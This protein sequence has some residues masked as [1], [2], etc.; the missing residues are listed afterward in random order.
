MNT[1]ITGEVGLFERRRAVFSPCRRYRY[2]LES[3]WDDRSGIATFVMLNP[4][5][6]H[7]THEDQTNTRCR[8]MAEHWGLGGLRFV[9]LFAWRAKEPRPRRGPSSSRRC[10]STP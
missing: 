3:V 4:S 5:T 8:G 7:E 9:N 2:L 6:A 1:E 10:R